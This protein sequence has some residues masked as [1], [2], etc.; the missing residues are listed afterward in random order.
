MPFD[1]GDG[2]TGHYLQLTTPIFNK[3]ELGC[4]LFIPPDFD[5]LLDKVGTF[6]RHAKHAVLLGG[7]A[8]VGKT[9][10]LVFYMHKHRNSRTI[11]FQ[12][13][14]GLCFVFQPKDTRVL[15]FPNRSSVPAAVFADSTA[16]Y[17]VDVGSESNPPLD[18]RA[19]TFAVAS[20]HAMKLLRAWSKQKMNVPELYLGRWSEAVLEQCRR[21]TRPE[22]TEAQAD[23][24][25][26]RTG[27]GPTFDDVCFLLSSQQLGER[28][29]KYG[30]LPR[31]VFL[32]PATSSAL[33]REAVGLIDLVKI[34]SQTEVL[35]MLDQNSTWIF[36]YV[37]KDFSVEYLDYASKYVEE[38]VYIKYT[39]SQRGALEL[40]FDMGREV[41]ISFPSCPA[42]CYCHQVCA[43]FAHAGWKQFERHAHTLLQAGGTFR[44][45]PLAI[46]SGAPV[47]KHISTITIPP[48]TASHIISTFDDMTRLNPG[49]Y[50]HCRPCFPAIDSLLQLPTASFYLFNFTVGKEHGV[51]EQWLRNALDRA[52]PCSHF[53][54]V[55]PAVV[56]MDFK[57]DSFDPA[58][59]KNRVNSELFWALE[60]YPPTSG[61]YFS[62]SGDSHAFQLF[63]LPRR[64]K[65]SRRSVCPFH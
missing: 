25:A 18:V 14:D 35:T 61:L 60:L 53:F 1:F 43:E 57:M 5:T 19:F 52:S 51:K 24:A 21:V 64:D 47:S 16:A 3:A 11:I 48:A 17:L 42:H 26:L 20:P 33:L 12:N 4:R 41:R 2:K 9:T 46:P 6:E 7:N 32:D 34:G 13:V 29:N 59:A 44:I 55:N 58:D 40:F 38:L 62:Q 49:E 10:F 54:F 27:T 28:I 36:H 22:A 39:T 37:V 23:Q 65:K 56:F 63:H 45:R 30:P 8:G 15:R 31:A 50:G